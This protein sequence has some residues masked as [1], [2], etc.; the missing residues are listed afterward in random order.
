MNSSI[1]LA[2]ESTV[3]DLN[4]GFR[5]FDFDNELS[6][7]DSHLDKFYLDQS[8]TR[9]KQLMFDSKCNEKYLEQSVFETQINISSSNIFY[10]TE[11]SFESI[12]CESQET[13]ELSYGSLAS[14]EN[15]SVMIDC[16]K[17]YTHI[18]K[19]IATKIVKKFTKMTTEINTLKPTKHKC[20]EYP[21]RRLNKK[22]IQVP[23]KVSNYNDSNFDNEASNRF[24]TFGDIVI[25]NI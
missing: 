14:S 17:L 23:D 20:S 6:I 4:E 16:K 7:T 5:T 21:H 22:S 18:M 9:I 12:K 11:L 2:K 10:S 15:K 8:D 1:E 13:K 3:E 24:N 19:P 25:Y